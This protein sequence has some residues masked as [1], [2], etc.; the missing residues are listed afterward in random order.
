MSAD[1]FPPILIG[2]I[3][4]QSVI[5]VVVA[6]KKHAVMGSPRP[7][8]WFFLE[9]KLGGIDAAGGSAVTLFSTSRSGRSR[10]IS[11]IKLDGWMSEV[12]SVRHPCTVRHY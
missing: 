1:I 6:V 3:N 12:I 7:S 10:L 4:Y 8:T 5:F 9:T 11:A 2:L